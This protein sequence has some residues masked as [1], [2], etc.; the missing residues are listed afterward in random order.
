MMLVKLSYRYQRLQVYK[1][2]TSSCG[3]RSISEVELTNELAA[4]RT[5]AGFNS[6]RLKTL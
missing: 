3:I 6:S 5:L 4:S 2:T 1:F